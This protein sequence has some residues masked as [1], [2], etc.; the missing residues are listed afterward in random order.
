MRWFLVP[1][2]TYGNFILVFRFHATQQKYMFFF[3]PAFLIFFY[4][5]WY[6]L[7]SF[8][9]FAFLSDFFFIVTKAF[10][11]P[12]ATRTIITKNPNR[13]KCNWVG[14]VVT[15]KMNP[16]WTATTRLHSHFHSRSRLRFHSHF[17]SNFH[18]HSVCNLLSRLVNL[19]HL[20]KSFLCSF[21]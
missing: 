5:F 3:L 14:G 8:P 10:K 15:K 21:I 9:L 4:F 19:W 17:H 1:V 6:F 7:V 16:L 20:L 11:K 18:S 12:P 13:R 2:F